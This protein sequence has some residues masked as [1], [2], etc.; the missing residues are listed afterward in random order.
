M[1]I[2][3]DKDINLGILKDKK[4]A[5]IGYGNQGSAQAKNMRDSGLEVIIGQR[6]GKTKEL[7]IK[8]GFEV[9]SIEN[10][11]KKADIIS[12]Q[13]PD[14]VQADIYKRKIQKNLKEGK[15]LNFSHG[16]NIRFNLIIPPK[17]VDVT[18][19]AP[20]GVG[21]MLRETF[22]NNSGVP[23]LIA[24]AQ[25]YSGNAKKIALALAKAIGSGRIGIIETTF[26]DET[27]ADL[28]TEQ[29]DL[30]GGVT[31]LIKTTFDI[32]VKR[33][34][35]PEVAYF[36]ALTELKLIV[37][38]IHKGGLA[39]MWSKVSNTA[40]YGGRVNGPRVIDRHVRKNM[41]KILEEIQTGKFA[42]KWIREYSRGM[43]NLKEMRK[44]DSMLRIEKIGRKIRKLKCS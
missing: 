31:E 44:K 6:R 11:V 12:I 27:D 20:K 22:L 17:N 18:L 34:Y 4:I 39:Y 24:V 13:L 2:Y 37:D 21:V 19:V 23:A 9:Y 29:V 7:A 26:A 10:A 25:D 41:E 16:F 15:V 5:V 28:F 1:K 42:K 36:E 43:P 3:Y 14:E 8:E 30:C 35:S 33:G 32:L 40:E 38:L